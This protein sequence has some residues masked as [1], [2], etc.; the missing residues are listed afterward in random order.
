MAL[1]WFGLWFGPTQ[2]S[3]GGR[4]NRRVI[5]EKTRNDVCWL[6]V[7]LMA[8]SKL[9]RMGAIAMK[10]AIAILAAIVLLSAC[11]VCA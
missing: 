2:D 7:F 6:F 11:P 3:I 4:L 9:T 8:E 10:Q 1:Q 5:L